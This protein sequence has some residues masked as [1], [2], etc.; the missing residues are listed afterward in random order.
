MMPLQDI[1]S[2]YNRLRASRCLFA[3]GGESSFDK[4]SGQ[5]LSEVEGSRS[6]RCAR[7]V[8]GSRGSRLVQ[9]YC[10]S[11]VENNNFGLARTVKGGAVLDSLTSFARS[12][13]K[14]WSGSRLAPSRKITALARTV[15]GGAVLDSLTSF[16]RSNSKCFARSNNKGLACSNSKCLTRSSTI[17][18]MQQSQIN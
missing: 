5:T 17:R 8:G 14:G 13:S 3:H 18:V 6:S 15:K 7:R 4:S 2:L 11:I 10:S 16:A 12:N 9:N 1:I